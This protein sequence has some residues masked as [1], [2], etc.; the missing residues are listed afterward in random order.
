MKVQWNLNTNSS[1]SAVTPRPRGVKNWKKKKKDALLGILEKI[2]VGCL[3]NQRIFNE[4][5]ERFLGRKPSFRR[6][7]K[8]KKTKKR[9]EEESFSCNMEK[10]ELGQTD[11]DLKPKR[12]KENRRYS[13][14]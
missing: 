1:Q 5:Q 9:R 3:K 8:S 10:S 7:K 12:P 11:Q 4:I 14:K 13:R 2:F 6:G